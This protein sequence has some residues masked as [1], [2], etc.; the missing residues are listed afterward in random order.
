MQDGQLRLRWGA[1]GWQCPAGGAAQ[2]KG[3]VAQ[4]SLLLEQGAGAAQS[5]DGYV[6]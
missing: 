4:E 2:A 6:K 1:A 3:I 5:V